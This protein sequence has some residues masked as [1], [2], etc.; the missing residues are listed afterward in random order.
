MS[1]GFVGGMRKSGGGGVC[2]SAAITF[3]GGSSQWHS[4]SRLCSFSER[5]LHP[6]V[7]WEGKGAGHPFSNTRSGLPSATRFRGTGQDS[8]NEVRPCLLRGPR[9]RATPSCHRPR[10]SVCAHCWLVCASPAGGG[11]A[12]ARAVAR[13]GPREGRCALCPPCTV[14]CGARA[15]GRPRLCCTPRGACHRLAPLPFTHHGCAVVVA[16]SP[17]GACGVCSLGSRVALP[18]PV[19][20]LHAGHP[21]P[22]PC[23]CPLPSQQAEQRSC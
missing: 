5:C 13:S 8:T 2:G 18:A 22:P 17:A 10:P 6:G 19:L 1:G 16:S 11:D 21:L 4:R 23:R 3:V 12:G 15:S 20:R 7:F 9:P 14:G